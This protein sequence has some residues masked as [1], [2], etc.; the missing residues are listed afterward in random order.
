M[1]AITLLAHEVIKSLS[2]TVVTI[3]Q[4]K[5]LLTLNKQLESTNK[6]ALDNAEAEIRKEALELR[7]QLDAKYKRDY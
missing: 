1:I 4:V 3:E 2:G 6:Q 7:A 5:L